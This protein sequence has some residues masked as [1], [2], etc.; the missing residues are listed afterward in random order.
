M[1]IAQADRR[2]P[3]FQGT[4]RNSR[5]QRALRRHVRI[6]N[7]G[8]FSIVIGLLLAAGFGGELTASLTGMGGMAW[9]LGAVILMALAWNARLNAASA[10]EFGFAFLP[11]LCALLIELVLFLDTSH[12]AD[13][14]RQ[15]FMILLG[16]AVYAA[17]KRETHRRQIRN[18]LLCSA[19]VIAALCCVMISRIVEGGWSYEAV[20]AS[21]NLLIK[22][23]GFGA[24]TACFAG[25]FAACAAWR[26]G[27]GQFAIGALI[28]CFVIFSI[29]LTARAPVLL[30]FVAAAISWPLAQ[31]DWTRLAR[32]A[33]TT[34]L[35]STTIIVIL[36]GTFLL[37]I[38]SIANSTVADLL[39]GRGALWQMGLRGWSDAPIIGNGIQTYQHVIQEHL[40]AATYRTPYEM[41]AAAT[42][43]GGGFHNIWVMV[44]VERGLIGFLGLSLTSALLLGRLFLNLHRFDTRGRFLALSLTSFIFLRGF[45]EITGMMSFADSALDAIVMIALAMTFAPNARRRANAGAREGASA[46]TALPL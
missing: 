40:G 5:E 9:R 24:N 45:V 7:W 14:A 17:A 31:L 12:L 16:S 25:L 29:M 33:D 39:A 37:S 22:N 21:K 32:R 20:R 28:A 42:L 46:P 6:V 11:W 38:E 19:L 1:A 26:A 30:L 34:F 23:T 44:L 41:R 13:F 35:L 36:V 3:G 4:G 18:V 8:V 27:R 43:S 2:Q 10:G 15:V